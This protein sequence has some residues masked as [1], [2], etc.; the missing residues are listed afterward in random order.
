M[1]PQ[2]PLLVLSNPDIESPEPPGRTPVTG[3][4][5][6]PLR[7]PDLLQASQPCVPLWPVLSLTQCEETEQEK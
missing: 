6:N 4:H 2:S 3:R 7:A 1:V 5:Q